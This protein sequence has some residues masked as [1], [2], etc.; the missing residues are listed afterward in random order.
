MQSPADPGD[1]S[2]EDAESLGRIKGLIMNNLGPLLLTN[3]LIV[4][5]DEREIH[6]SNASN[7]LFATKLVDARTPDKS[8]VLILKTTEDGVKYSN[9]MTWG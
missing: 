4:N 2:G 3:S 1:F 9:K 7:T 5:L 6:A 8:C